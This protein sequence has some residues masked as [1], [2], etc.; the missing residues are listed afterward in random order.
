MPFRLGAAALA[1]ILSACVTEAPS[2]TA[3]G[4]SPPAVTASARPAPSPAS[5]VP[6]APATP[7]PTPLVAL[8]VAGRPYDAADLLDAMRAS[9]RPGGVPDA[10]ETEA[11]ATA[12]AAEIWT[13]DGA[14]WPS[15]D[16]GGSCGPQE[17]TI[18]VAGA[19]PGALGEDLYVFSIRPAS[20]TVS[21][22]DASLRGL[23][24]ALLPDLDE[25]ARTV[26]VEDLDDLVLGSARWLPPPG[27]GRFVLAYR[28]GGEE[29]SP[30]V[31]VLLDVIEG[32]AVPIS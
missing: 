12:M 15:I 11:I 28:S 6:T 22:L 21:I 4:I 30:A 16:A 18:E 29:G 7:E 13:F 9:R 17:C 19:A 2:P 31:D 5:A 3:A 23:P 26:S 25:A 8:P 10:V 27:A 32:T 14:P 24:A 1:V 20:G